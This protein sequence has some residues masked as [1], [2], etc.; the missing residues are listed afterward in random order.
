MLIL[1]SILGSGTAAFRAQV[2]DPRGQGLRGEQLL[3]RPHAH[4][5]LLSHHGRKV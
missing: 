4:R 2:Q 3:Q 1:K 5:V